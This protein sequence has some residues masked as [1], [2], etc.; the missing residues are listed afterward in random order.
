MYSIYIKSKFFY[1]F[2]FG[3]VVNNKKNKNN[4]FDLLIILLII[5]NWGNLSDLD[6]VTK[7][8]NIYLLT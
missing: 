8:N 2:G 3:T 4:Y 1:E 5:C 6:Q 7:I